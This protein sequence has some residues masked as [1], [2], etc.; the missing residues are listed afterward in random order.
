MSANESIESQ[1][2]EFKSIVLIQARFNSSRLPG[3]ALFPI[4]GIPVVVLAALRAGNTGKN[5]VVVTSDEPADDEICSALEKYKIK[6]FRGSLNDVLDRFFHALADESSE[7]IVFRLTADNVLPDGAFLDEMESEFIK[8]DADIMHCLPRISNLPYGLSAEVT[9]VKHIREAFRHAKDSYDREHVTPYIYRKRKEQVFKSRQFMGYSNFRVTIDNYV[10]Y[11]CVKSLFRSVNDI[12]SE[13]IPSLM[14]NFSKMK[15]R[16]YYEPTPK[17]MTLGTVQLGLNYGITN[18]NGMVS[19][20]EAIEII[21]ISVTEGVEYID[22]AAAYGLSQAVIGEAL[23][24]GWLSRVKLIT[25]ITPFSADEFSDQRSWAMALRN[26][27]YQSCINL[28][29][30]KIDVLMFH[31]YDNALINSL[32]NEVLQ[33]KEEGLITEIGVSVQSPEELKAVLANDHFTFVQLPF[34][35]LDFRWSE[36]IKDVQSARNDRKLTVHARS[37]LLQGLLCS[38]VDSHWSKA[39]IDNHREVIE[40]LSTTYKKFEKMS[41]SDLCIGY[42]NSQS[43]IDSVV[44]GVDSISN[45]YSNLRS[46]SMPFMSQ[47]SLALIVDSRPVVN[48]SSLNPSTWS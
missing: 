23:S 13:S 24:G 25:K 6:Y 28:R 41:V 31:R 20:K 43:W 47:E 14:S 15:Y 32:Y 5:V 48:A 19:K 1:N 4:E 12:V 40:W 9:R 37:S 38:E 10:D 27:F 36:L 3:K 35:I 2:H 34:N 11:V 26:S 39:G 7:R 21:R 29:T 33:L 44:I 16:P 46:V 18:L 42:V 22:T 30:S 8:S 45:L 17:P